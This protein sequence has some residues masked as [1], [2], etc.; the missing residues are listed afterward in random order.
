MSER[1]RTAGWLGAL[2]GGVA[3]GAVEAVLAVAF[4]A[5]A[6]NGLVEDYI[7]DGIALFLGG[8]AA[9]LAVMAVLA[10][11]RGIVGAPQA[12]PAAVVGLVAMTTSLD[13]FGGPERSFLTVVLGTVVVTVLAGA[14]CLVL[15]ATRRGNLLRFIPGPIVGA[16]LAGT[17]WLLL[18]GGIAV[19]VGESP[20]LLPLS[21][22]T[23]RD[24]LLKW[25][26]TVAFGVLMLVALRVWKRPLAIPVALAFGFAAFAI[27]MVVSGHTFQDARSF[28]WLVLGPFDEVTT[29]QPWSI[30]AVS[31]ADRAA[32]LW[33][34]AGVLAAVF[35]T[36]LVA[37]RDIN[38]TEG[39]IDRDLDTNRELRDAG[40]S[41]V[42]AG[43]F[44]G[45]P[46]HHAV[47]STELTTWLRADARLTGVLAAVV[48]LALL[49][50]GGA[51]IERIPR[52]VVGGMLVFLG[53]A[54]LVEWVWDRRR[55][56]SRVEYVVVLVVLAAVIAR[57]FV[58]GVLLGLVASVVLFAISYGRVDQV[59]EVPFGRIARSNVDRPAGERD[60]LEQMADLVQVLRLDG[61]VFF[62]SSNAL[63]ERIR[64]RADA[65]GVRFIVIDLRRVSGVDS[66]AVA[67]FVKIARVAGSH[68]IELVLTGASEAVR[69]KLARGGV[70]A[71][72]GVVTFA[73]D[74]D[75]GLQRC[76]DALLAETRSGDGAAELRAEMP[77]GLA[78]YLRR[79]EVPEGTVLIAQNEA[80]E[81]VFVLESGRLVVE[82]EIA[83]GTRVRLGTIR[84]GVVVGEVAMYTGVPRTADVIAETPVV[85]LRLTRV[86]A[87]RGW[88]PSSQRS[89]RRRIDGSP[90]RSRSASPTRSAPSRR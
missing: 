39:V 35:V 27:G 85:L 63:L 30:R 32:V 11:R 23:E 74:L 36:I 42:V 29:W 1:S 25:V 81:D 12:A 52:I 54:F 76:E 51:V 31:G 64:G 26:P 33:Q 61:F 10:G 60:A 41:N 6:F 28:G 71:A 62:G 21:A 15:G 77:L 9:T 8:A 79:E 18:R 24:A 67:S 84:P 47:R 86:G 70:V 7:A 5:L 49:V 17:G 40:I 83:N 38:A 3:I 58:S 14:I 22:L 87:R 20:F 69:G 78:D 37:F 44:G 34:G 66:S 75:R 88:R 53:L 57:G 50:I 90:R 13:A 55:E 56:L 48:P 59:R 43:A 82:T 19:S 4:A 68:G 46:G 45:I 80:P 72:D 16:F 89:P 65:G 2:G 73:S